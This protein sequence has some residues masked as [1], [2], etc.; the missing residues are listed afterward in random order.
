MSPLKNKSCDIIVSNPPY[1]CSYDL[2]LDEGELAFEP[3]AAL[4]G[5]VDGLDIIRILANKAPGKLKA[6]G[7][8]LVEHG[9]DQARHVRAILA[10]ETFTCIETHRDLSGHERMTQGRLA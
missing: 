7:W 5:G 1:V 8:L 10:Q 3:R 4:V 9:I 2:C 6:R